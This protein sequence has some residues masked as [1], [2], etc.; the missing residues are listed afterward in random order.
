MDAARVEETRA[1]SPNRISERNIVVDELTGQDH[2]HSSRM[3][4]N[5]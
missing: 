5:L 1:R 3:P 2:G 4:Q